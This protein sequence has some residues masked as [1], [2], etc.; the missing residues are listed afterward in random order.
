[1]AEKKVE[2]EKP[3][4]KYKTESVDKIA[5]KFKASRTV[6][7]ASIKSLPTSK[8][9][10]IKKN[11]IGKAEVMVAKKSVVLRAIDKVKKGS[12]KDLKELVKADIC[13]MFSELDAFELAG[14]LV[15]NQTPSNAKAGDVAPEDINVEPGPTSLIPGPAISELGAVGI[16]VAVEGGKLTIKQPV[17]IVKAGEVI[18]LK[19]A[20][21]LAKLG[22]APMKVGFIPVGAYDS[23]EDKVYRDIKIDKE[24]TLEE[25]RTSIGKALGFAVNIG[26]VVKETISCFIWK[27]AAEEKALEKIYEEKSGKPAEV[28]KTEATEEEKPAEEEKKEE[29][30]EEGK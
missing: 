12:M 26:H 3:I 11:L 1:M 9:Q 16:K 17:T 24:G 25:L 2:R 21:V 4:P 30:K 14:V 5:E 23:E 29:A 22:I 20:S 10:K 28:E 27:A 13:L 15:D 19:V 7:I 18:N 8:F 6:F